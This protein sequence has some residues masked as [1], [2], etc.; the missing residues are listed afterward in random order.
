VFSDR[1]LF[2]LDCFT[3][4]ANS[5]HK[6][7]DENKNIAAAQFDLDQSFFSRVE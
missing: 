4:V 1:A 2:S 7:N 3:V 5:L 6:K